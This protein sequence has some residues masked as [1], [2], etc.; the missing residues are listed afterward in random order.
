MMTD[1]NELRV[2]LASKSPRRRELLRLIVPEFE[3]VSADTDE[4]CNIN[5]PSELAEELAFRKASEVYTALREKKEIYKNT[6]VIGCDTVVCVNGEILGKPKNR[7]DA[8]RM[9][10]CL[11]GGWHRVISGV[12]IIKENRVRVCSQ[13]TDV[14]FDKL[15]D[16]EIESYLDTD[17]PY[18]KAGAYGIQG[19]AAKF[20]K[21]IRGCYHN[22]VGLPVNLIYRMLFDKI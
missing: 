1:S 13:A 9:I 4:A 21:E 17:E 15:S 18:D 6:A 5:V 16:N 12:A 7:D 22:V 20:V 19:Y 8:R 2:I 11:S 10:K 14:C 3:A